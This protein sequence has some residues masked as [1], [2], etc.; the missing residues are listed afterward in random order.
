MNPKNAIGKFESILSGYS[1]LLKYAKAN[2][3]FSETENFDHS[4]RKEKVKKFIYNLKK[5]N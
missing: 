2:N 1:D 3:A 4:I 5:K